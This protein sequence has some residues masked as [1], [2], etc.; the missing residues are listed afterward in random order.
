MAQLPQSG[1]A[2]PPT[3]SLAE[4]E[5]V[6]AAVEADIKAENERRKRL[7]AARAAP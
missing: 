4:V 1:G 5:A 2:P 3:Q 7:L 6:A